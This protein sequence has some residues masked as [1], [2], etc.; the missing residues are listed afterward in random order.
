MFNFNDY[1]EDEYQFTLKA[2]SYKLVEND[3]NS[4]QLNLKVIDT[5]T[6][7]SIEKELNIVFERKV[8][9]EPAAVYDIDVVFSV[10]VRFKEQIDVD[11]IDIN[12]ER[13]LGENET[14]YLSNVVSR[15][16]NII[17]MITASYGQQ[18]LITPPSPILEA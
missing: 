13:I 8:F 9:F 2:L 7:N 3:A 16:S 17:A 12:W 4:K 1:F 15:A 6:T 11:S 18:P 10:D 14:P 5:I